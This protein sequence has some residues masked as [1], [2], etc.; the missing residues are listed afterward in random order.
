MIKINYIVVQVTQ[1]YFLAIFYYGQIACINISLF[2]AQQPEFI[3]NF[4]QATLYHRFAIK[5]SLFR[6]KFY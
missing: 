4:S 2:K 6:Y 3:T 5:L 1:K